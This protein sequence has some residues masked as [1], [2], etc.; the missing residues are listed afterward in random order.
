[1]FF[2]YVKIFKTT[3]KD[4]INQ[5]IKQ[6]IFFLLIINLISFIIMMLD[7][8][9][10]IKKQWRIS[11]RNL[12]LLAF[13]GGGFGIYIGMFIFKHKIRKKKFIFCIPII[14]GFQLLLV[15]MTY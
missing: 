13:L 7:K 15:F 10:A 11:E 14:I 2:F 3:K 4:V 6:A 5:M 12:F 1:M 9:R 8:Y